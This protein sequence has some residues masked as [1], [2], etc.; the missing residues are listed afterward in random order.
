VLSQIDGDYHMLNEKDL[1]NLELC[2][3]DGFIRQLTAQEG[4]FLHLVRPDE[5]LTSTQ[6]AMEKDYLDELYK[7]ASERLDKLLLTEANTN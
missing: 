2:T 7:N 4:S 5:L 3:I 6:I 1:I